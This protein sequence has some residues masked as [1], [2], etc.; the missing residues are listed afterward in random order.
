MELLPAVRLLMDR[1]PGTRI[2][3]ESEWNHHEKKLHAAHL[4]LPFRS[5]HKAK[6]AT[7]PDA[8]ADA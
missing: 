7:Q 6:T 8:G 1:F 2:V 4:A 5:P 3:P